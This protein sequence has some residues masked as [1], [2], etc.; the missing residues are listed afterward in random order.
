MKAIK[1]LSLVIAGG[2]V[3]FLLGSMV[4]NQQEPVAGTNK[5]QVKSPRTRKK[6]TPSS[7]KKTRKKKGGTENI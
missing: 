5:Q 7:A 2:I 6:T 4:Y 1:I 3:G